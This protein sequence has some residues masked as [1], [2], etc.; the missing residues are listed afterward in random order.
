MLRKIF[1]L[2]I[3]AI[4]GALMTSAVCGEGNFIVKNLSNADIENMVQA[5]VLKTPY[6]FDP[7]RLRLLI[8]SYYDFEGKSHEDGK[9]IVLDAVADSVLKI[10]QELYKTKFP[11]QEIK[12]INEFQ[13][14]DDLAM[15][16][17]NSSALNQRNITGQ[18]ALSLHAYGLALDINP[19]QN[20]YISFDF[21]KG[22]AQYLPAAG[23]KFANRYE[24][25]P[26]KPNRPGLAEPLKKLFYQN[27]FNIWGGNW[28]YPIDY[29]H[30]QTSR[31][32]EELLIA[33]DPADAEEFF[34]LHIKF[35]ER[36]KENSAAELAL[37]MQNHANKDLVK[38][39]LVNK[40]RFM[41]HARKVVTQ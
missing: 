17:N 34:K 21:D 16:A 29:Q 20:P 37:Y 6:I 12:L 10:F 8:V 7:N 22:T 32:L 24:N 2:I 28:D 19:I 5:N 25:R 14:N 15:A 13:G 35:L 26:G 18:T 4:F 27:G 38:D 3:I 40:K 30:F 33:M 41:E 36:Q 39:Y 9:I 23:A 11:F 1:H 31:T